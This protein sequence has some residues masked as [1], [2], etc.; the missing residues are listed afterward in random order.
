MV[1]FTRPPL[2]YIS[3]GIGNADDIG[4]FFSL[5]RWGCTRLATSRKSWRQP[6]GTTCRPP[7]ASRRRPASRSP[8]SCTGTF[9]TSPRT[10]AP[11]WTGCA[12]SCP[13]SGG[14]TPSRPSRP[15]A[16][17]R[18]RR[19]SRLCRT[20][21]GSGIFWPRRPATVYGLDTVE[22]QNGL[23]FCVAQVCS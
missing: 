3:F 16:G 14:G 13:A 2:G 19:L 20:S 11:S 4:V 10:W 6:R 9:L 15:A 17:A 22:G 5:R 7:S 8:S 1:F 21:S 18:R 12:C 23:F